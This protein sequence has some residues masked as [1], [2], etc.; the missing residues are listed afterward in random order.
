MANR[1]KAQCDGNIRTAECRV[2]RHPWPVCPNG[3]KAR[4]HRQTPRHQGTRTAPP[5]RP[6]RSPHRACRCQRPLPFPRRILT[7]MS[8]PQEPP[9][10]MWRRRLRTA[11]HRH[12][13]PSQAACPSTRSPTE[14]FVGRNRHISIK[15]PRG[16]QADPDVLS[17]HGPAPARPPRAGKLI[18]PGQPRHRGPRPRTGRSGLTSLPSITQTRDYRSQMR[19]FHPARPA[20]S[21]QAGDRRLP[22]PRKPPLTRR[23]TLPIRP[24]LSPSAIGRRAGL[25]QRQG[26]TPW[27]AWM[28][29]APP[30]VPATRPCLIPRAFR[31]RSSGPLHPRSSC[32]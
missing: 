22:C 16:R 9:N 30:G 5:N 20:R 10:P 11:R 12:V 29:N 14:I 24:L 23:T 19:L 21:G 7:S 1:A 13:A 32:R 25:P 15:Q 2:P 4:L 31:T 28:P 18:R 27:Q 26:A 8:G 6:C 3:R 17:P